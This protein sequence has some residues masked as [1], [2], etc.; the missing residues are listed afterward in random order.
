MGYLGDGRLGSFLDELTQNILGDGRL[1]LVGEQK[2]EKYT[3]ASIWEQG[4]W[5]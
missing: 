2:W 1:T 5:P 4:D 3:G